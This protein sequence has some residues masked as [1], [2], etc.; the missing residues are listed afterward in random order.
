MRSGNLEFLSSD[1]A[2]LDIAL[3]TPKCVL[4][5]RDSPKSIAKL[6]SAGR[7]ARHWRQQ[8]A[9]QG[10]QSLQASLHL[11]T[12]E[13]LCAMTG[14]HLCRLLHF[15]PRSSTEAKLPETLWVLAGGIRE[16][17]R[18]RSVAAQARRNKRHRDVANA[19][20]V[21]DVIIQ[22]ALEPKLTVIRR[23]SAAHKAA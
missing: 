19:W 9:G 1:I 3:R 12:A 15:R 21:V 6:E 14:I 8:P 23:R 7:Q 4:S 13:T 2:Y 20:A 16:T 18:W 10:G 17:V 22:Q 11:P 5:T